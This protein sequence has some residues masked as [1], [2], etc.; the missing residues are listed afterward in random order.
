[1]AFSAL[2]DACVLYPA[3]LRDLLVRLARTGLFRA[4]WSGRIHEEWIRGV[5]RTRP[6]LADR[7]ARTRSLMDQAVEDALVIGHEALIP[8][9]VLPDADDRHVLA[10]AIVGRADVIVTFNLKHFPSGPLAPYRIEAQ[11]P[12]VFIRHVLDL[13]EAVAL[14]AVKAHRASLRRPAVSVDGY[15][16][17]L[18]RQGLPETVAFLRP[19]EEFL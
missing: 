18:T 6:D 11:H 8:D 2:F 10:A 5:L 14:G 1:M 15:L 3:P 19:W 4:R 12:D 16:D 17:T 13:D 9:L 7:L